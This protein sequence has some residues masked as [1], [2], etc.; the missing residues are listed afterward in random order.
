MDLNNKDSKQNGSSK[1]TLTAKK[2]S[3]KDSLEPKYMEILKRLILQKF[4][5]STCSQED[6]PAKTSVM[7]EK[8]M[9]SRGVALHSGNITSK[10]LGKYDQE[11]HSL[12]TYQ[13]LLIEDSTLCLETLPRSGMMQN[14]IV[15]QLPALVRLTAGTGSSLLP[16][17]LKTDA[18]KQ[19]TGSLS[20]MVKM[21]PTP[22]KNDFKVDCPAE[23]RR[24]SPHLE[25]V[26]KMR[27]N[28]S[29]GET[30]GVGQLNP[31]F[32]EWL[33]G[34]PIGWTELSV[35]ETQSFRNVQKSLRKQ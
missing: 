18:D 6:S 15:Y 27:K 20:R 8:E 5:E 34:F 23:R 12:K 28:I 22:I 19:A 7:L 11:S 35:L 24:D 16:T 26:V 30:K 31:E 14:G 4:Q 2:S 21:W 33:M 3:R 25:S 9:A 1:T 32:V 10:R 13:H 29:L 17:P